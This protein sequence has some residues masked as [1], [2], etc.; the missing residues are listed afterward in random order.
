MRCLG[1]IWDNDPISFQMIFFD[2]DE[3]GDIPT[4]TYSTDVFSHFNPV[5]S[6]D[7]VAL[8]YFGLYMFHEHGQQ[9][10]LP[11]SSSAI[12]LKVRVP[13]YPDGTTSPD[14]LSPR[15]IKWQNI[16]LTAEPIVVK[17]NNKQR[18]EEL[19]DG[20][21]VVEKSFLAVHGMKL[22]TLYL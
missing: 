3:Y 1:P 13:K 22:Q 21:L 16:V 11:R 9:V 14:D 5:V 19:R 20:G 15:Y 17:R 6:E 18:G 2:T 10:E 12:C 8:S 4:P 7:T